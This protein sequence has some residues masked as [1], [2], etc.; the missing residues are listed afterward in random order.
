[1]SVKARM[2]DGSLADRSHS[3]Y[4]TVH[5]PVVNSLVGLP[6]FP[7]APSTAFTFADA[8]ATNFR[9]LNHFFDVDRAQSTR[10]LH[11][12]LAHRPGDPL[13]QHDRRRLPRQGLLRRH[14]G[15]PTRHQRRRHRSAT[16]PPAR[17]PLP[18]LAVAVLDGSR[19][20]CDWG[21]DPDAVEPGIF[22]PSNLPHLFRDDYVTNGNDSYWLSNPEQPLE[23]FARIIG[24]E[25]TARSLRTRLGLVMVAAHHRIARAGQSS[26][27][28]QLQATAF[29]NRQYAG[30]L[31]RDP[32]LAMCEQNPTLPGSSGPVD[33]SAACPVLAAW[34]LRDDLDAAGAIL[35]R[36]FA[37]RVLASPAPV[38]GPQGVFTVPFDVADPVNTPARP[39]HR[40]PERAAR[41]RRRRQR[42]ARRRHPARRRPARTPVRAASARAGLAIPTHGGPG[43]LGVFNA[44]NVPWVSGEGY[45]DT[46]HG[47]SFVIAASING[48]RCPPVRTILTYSQSENPR[49]PTSPT[50]RACLPAS[51]GSVDRF[52]RGQILADPKLRVIRLRCDGARAR[53]GRSGWTGLS[54][55]D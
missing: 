29:N 5:G 2:P 31:F 43:T 46:P 30:E 3:F 41:A 55:I 38:G 21:S 50:R 53:R 42:P 24:D 52:C 8:N 34:T 35:F 11:R 18:T 20:S 23:G 45:P 10:R 39:R 26:P 7:W 1:M 47:S 19:S 40:Q 48:A 36:R 28:R 6:L 54:G 9:Y 12:V 25:R 13:G 49:S 17:R 27:S 15:R 33:V 44:I 16:P 22:G 14:L 51:D 37:S 32:L 4:S